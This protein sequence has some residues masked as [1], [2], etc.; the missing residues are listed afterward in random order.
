M[1]VVRYQDIELDYCTECWGVWFDS[2]ELELLL[3]TMRLE[4]A[5]LGGG[6]IL[7]LPEAA[8]REKKRHCPICG[9]RMKKVN[10]GQPLILIDACGQGHGLWFDD[11]EVTQLAAQL[12][13]KPGDTSQGRVINFLGEVFKAGGQV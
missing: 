5:V 11:G 7:N 1:I 10:I 9:H 3:D 6:T 8:S 12:G 2:G 4:A 13:K